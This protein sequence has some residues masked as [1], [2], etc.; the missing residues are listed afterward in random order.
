MSIAFRKICGFSEIVHFE[1]KALTTPFIQAAYAAVFTNPWFG[2]G[3]VEDLSPQ[4]AELSPALG[5]TLAAHCIEHLGGPDH[6]ACFGKAALV[7]LSGEIE[8]ANALI[9]TVEFG[10]PIRKAIDGATWM[11]SSQKRGTAG[12]SLEIPVAHKTVD[13]NQ[14]SYHSVEIRI[15]DAPMDNEIVVAVAMTASVRPHARPKKDA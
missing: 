11:V 13:K 2:A 3:F 4:I 15:P 5:E 12:C 6:V 10:N 7:G 9:H 8:H 14:A 1:G